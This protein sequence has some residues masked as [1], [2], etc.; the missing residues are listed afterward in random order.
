MR[1]GLIFA[2]LVSMALPVAAER[3]FPEQASSRFF[4]RADYLE[5]PHIGHLVALVSPSL[6]DKL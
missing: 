2:C 5:L 4:E 3:I 6:N 1:I